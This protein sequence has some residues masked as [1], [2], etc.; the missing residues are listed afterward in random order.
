MGL[1]LP[2]KRCKFELGHSSS[3]GSFSDSYV[4]KPVKYHMLLQQAEAIFNCSLY[5]IFW[6]EFEIHYHSVKPVFV[7]SLQLEDTRFSFD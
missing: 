6:V 1:D 3:V 7:Q 4:L 2:K 5:L